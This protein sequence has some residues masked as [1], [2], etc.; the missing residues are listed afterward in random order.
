MGH[1]VCGEH[2]GPGVVSF[3]V[4]QSGRGRLYGGVHDCV[5]FNDATLTTPLDAEALPRV[6]RQSKR[7]GDVDCC[8]LMNRI[9]PLASMGGCAVSGLWP[10]RPF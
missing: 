2:H 3:D 4:G 1:L 6:P 8:V 9:L 10:L 5:I 7:S